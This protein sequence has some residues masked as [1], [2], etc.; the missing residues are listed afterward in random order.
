MKYIK[1][2]IVNGR[3]KNKTDDGRLRK[4]HMWSNND[5]KCKMYSSGG[6]GD[7]RYIKKTIKSIN[8]LEFKKMRKN[9]KICANCVSE[10]KIDIKNSSK[11]VKVIK[12][13][14]EFLPIE[15]YEGDYE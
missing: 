15:L 5:T 2:M 9:G 6:L 13:P 14:K 10:S 12:E 8:N 7:V 11:V 4:H 1:I 3:F